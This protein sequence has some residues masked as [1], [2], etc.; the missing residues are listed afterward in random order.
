MLGADISNAKKEDAGAILADT[1]R[2]YMDDL[3]IENGITGL[4]YTKSDIP[5][6]VKGTL[7]QQ[8]I[9]KLAPRKQT[10]EDLTAL[11]EDALTVY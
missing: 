6:L 11:F 10:E 8:R 9:I 3:K 5:S 1:V 7:P 4:G 2:K